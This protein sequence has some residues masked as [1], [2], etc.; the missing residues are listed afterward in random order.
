MITAGP[1]SLASA[2]AHRVKESAAQDI[3]LT[4]R[5]F[6]FYHPD[7]SVWWLIP[8]TEWP[9]FK[10]GKVFFDSRLPNGSFDPASVFCGFYIEKGLGASVLTVGGYHPSWI[11][12]DDWLWRE[13]INSLRP[14]S[15]LLPSRT[16]LGIYASYFPPREEGGAIDPI[17]T[18]L[19]RRQAFRASWA[20]FKVEE[21]SRLGLQDHWLNPD[22]P[23]IQE[24][25]RDRILSAPTL[26]DL[27]RPLLT[28]PQQEWVWVDL[29]AGPIV[30]QGTPAGDLWLHHL[31][32]WLPWLRSAR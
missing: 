19:A 16:I 8:S 4:A 22:N 30:S 17:E 31:R 25:Y 7:T 24:H 3:N 6:D 27:A 11:M 12:Q 5:P 13:F 32:L 26:S 9:A 14:N 23:E 20:S 18:L 2:M 29:Y 28:F 15:P 1:E 10:F 21:G